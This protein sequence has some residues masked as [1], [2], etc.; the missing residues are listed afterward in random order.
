VPGLAVYFTRDE[1]G[2]PTALLHSLKH[3]HVLHERVVLLTIRTALLPHMESESRLR[4]EELAT[5]MGRVVLTFGFLD[6]PDVPEALKL[7][8]PAWREE[9]MRTSYVL[10]RQIL[11]HA[12]RPGMSRWREALFSALVRFSSSAMEYYRLPPG[13]VVELGSQVE[14]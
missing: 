5:G 2:V 10:G 12:A 4:F 13:R 1:A 11:I 9:P 8:P 3:H 14:I 6:E 7:L